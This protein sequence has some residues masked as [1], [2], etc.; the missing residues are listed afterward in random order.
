L[1]ARA[2]LEIEYSDEGRSN[3][4]RACA[5]PGSVWSVAYRDRDL[6]TPAQSGYVRAAC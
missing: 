1:V 2:P 5:A 3:F 4:D 6:R